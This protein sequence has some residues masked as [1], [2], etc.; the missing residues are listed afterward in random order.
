WMP[1]PPRPQTPPPLH[2]S[3]NATL[4]SM[5]A[6]TLR[7]PSLSSPTV[8][9]GISH[10]LFAVRLDRNGKLDG[11]AVDL[12]KLVRLLRE[13]PVAPAIEMLHY[14]H[15]HRRLLVIADLDLEALVDPVL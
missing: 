10:R 15:I 14:A 3:K 6:L 8:M 9:D 4:A 2:A 7:G 13:V 12:A 5:K 1:M 11:L